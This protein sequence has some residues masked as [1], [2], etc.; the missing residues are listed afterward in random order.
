MRGKRILGLTWLTPCVAL[1]VTDSFLKISD[2]NRGSTTDKCAA[3]ASISFYSA[4]IL[5]SKLGSIRR[6]QQDLRRWRRWSKEANSW[7]S[8][9]FQQIVGRSKDAPLW[10]WSRRVAVVRRTARKIS[11]GDLFRVLIRLQLSASRI[12]H[13]CMQTSCLS[14]P[15]KNLLFSLSETKSVTLSETKS[16]VVSDTSEAHGRA[17][18]IVSE[19]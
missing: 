12:F 17:D 16:K 7:L 5:Q 13:Y 1:R 15:K 8:C 9:S 18:P 4:S 6:I 10:T 3:S 2:L 19:M 14:A 11:V